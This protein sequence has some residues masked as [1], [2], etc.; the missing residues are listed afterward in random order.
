MLPSPDDVG[1]SNTD[2]DLGEWKGGRSGRE[3]GE[4]HLINKYG[5]RTMLEARTSL[6]GMVDTTKGWPI[7][8]EK[9]YLGLRL[10]CSKEGK[11]LFR[12]RTKAWTC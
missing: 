11:R 7:S 4:K 6:R 3:V 12:I 9:G 5:P 10:F 1:V 8:T 2:P